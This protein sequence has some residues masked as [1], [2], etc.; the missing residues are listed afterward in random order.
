MVGVLGTSNRSLDMPAKSAAIPTHRRSSVCILFTGY[1]H[2][3]D[4]KLIRVL[5]SFG[6]VLTATTLPG[7]SRFTP[8]RLGDVRTGL[9]VGHRGYHL[10]TTFTCTARAASGADVRPDFDWQ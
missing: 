1:P 4:T 9:P 3:S 5:D 10:E 8:A 6:D 7:L 2:V